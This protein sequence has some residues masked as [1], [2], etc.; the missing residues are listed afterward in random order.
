M[1]FYL[2]IASWILLII[3]VMTTM[4]FISDA[5]EERNCSEVIVRIN[6]IGEYQFIEEGDLKEE[7]NLQFNTPVSQKIMDIDTDSIEK[8][9]LELPSIASVNAFITI[10]GKLVVD[11][12]QRHP[13]LRVFSRNESYYIDRTGQLMALSNRHSA[14]VLVVNGHLREPFRKFRDIDLDH[15]QTDDSLASTTMLDD[16]YRLATYIDSHPFW[17]AQIEQ[18]YVNKDSEVELIPRVGSHTIVLGEV[19]DIEAKFGKLMTFYRKGL[20][21]T[22]WNEYKVINLKYKNQVVCTKR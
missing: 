11:V 9:L 5:V 3:G 6:D 21:N 15:L 19:A 20:E 14:Q 16:L 8:Y 2:K 7:I 13:I 10:D 18:L 22:G 1:K 4:G 17:K 12:R